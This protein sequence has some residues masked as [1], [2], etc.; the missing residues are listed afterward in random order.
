[1]HSFAAVWK[2]PELSSANLA[3]LSTHSVYYEDVSEF[4]SKSFLFGSSPQE[5]EISSLNALGC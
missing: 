2:G 1:M 5:V 3:E 4:S